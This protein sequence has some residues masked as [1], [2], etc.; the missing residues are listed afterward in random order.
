M[1]K[2]DSPDV[3]FAR[4]QPYGYWRA[5]NPIV[6]LLGFITMMVGTFAR[7]P[8]LSIQGAMIVFVMLLMPFKPRSRWQVFFINFGLGSSIVS[9]DLEQAEK[10]G[11]CEENH[12]KCLEISVL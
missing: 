8:S 10:M 2:P 9:L 4:N 1:R 6:K 7:D 3:W 11:E 5:G 12:S